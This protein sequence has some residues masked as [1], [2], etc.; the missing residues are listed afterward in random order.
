MHRSIALFVVML[1]V[2]GAVYATEQPP[3]DES[4]FDALPG[5]AR[6]G[7]PEMSVSD[8]QAEFVGNPANSM[9][10]WWPEDL[11]LVPIPGRTP[12]FGWSLAAVGGYFLDL[13]KSHP[14]TP[15]SIIGAFGWYAE[16]KSWAG[17][18]ASKL[19][20]LDDKIRINLAAAYADVNY[21]FYGV[22]NDA[23]DNGLSV[24]IDQEVPIYFGAVKYEFFP[25][26]YLGIG[27]LSSKVTTSLTLDFIP[28]EFFPPGALPPDFEG[29]EVERRNAAIGV[30]L[31]ID[32]RDNEQFPREGWHVT[33]RTMFYREFVGSDVETETVTVAVNHYRPMR[34]RDVLAMRITT[35]ATGDD[36]PFYLLSTFGGRTDLRGYESGRYRDRM[37][38]AAQ[39]EYRWQPRDR[40]L[41]TGFAGVGEVA[42]SYSQFFS[43]FLPAA[44]IGA[45]FVLSPKHKLN[46][47][48]DVAVGKHGAEFYF[49]V[50]EAF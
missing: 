43:N 47:A 44:G 12:E 46:L 16:N 2:A 29:F 50:G 4:D 37:M 14:E 17:G 10:G 1:V 49:G 39:A 40:W 34:E 25:K 48:L 28:P 7:S 24:R 21:R 15:S 42:P 35:R 41:F 5:Q 20:V 32:T 30:P 18:V 22:G 31:E 23:G 33:A 26:T 9:F 8:E 19:N 13:D 3:E 6:F 27:L 36:A 45:R 11:V 38:Y